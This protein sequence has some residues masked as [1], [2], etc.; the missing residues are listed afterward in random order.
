MGTSAVADLVKSID[1]GYGYFTDESDLGQYS[2]TQQAVA[3]AMTT[4]VK[5]A[6]YA[7]TDKTYQLGAAPGQGLQLFPLVE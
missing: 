7:I 1:Q 6:G 5:G 3:E 4:L 2:T